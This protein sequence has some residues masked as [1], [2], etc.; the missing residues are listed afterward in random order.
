M[1]RIGTVSSRLDIQV[2]CFGQHLVAKVLTELVR[3]LQISAPAQDVGE[4]FLHREV[5]EAGGLALLELD[6]H[7][8][9]AIRREVVAEYRAEKGQAAN[10]MAPAEVDDAI[11]RDFDAHP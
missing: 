1:W 10:M 3:R 8:Y 5:G 4:L 11:V 9:V 2:L 6:K 7:I